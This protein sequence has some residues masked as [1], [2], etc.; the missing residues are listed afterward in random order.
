MIEAEKRMYA[1]IIEFG[2]E[3]VGGVLERSII[4]PIIFREQIFDLLAHTAKDL[5]K[6]L[7]RCKKSCFQ[8]L[9]CF[10]L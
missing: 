7:Y 10:S 2:N 3:V 6:S 1:G 8:K 4:N 9:Y 5:Q